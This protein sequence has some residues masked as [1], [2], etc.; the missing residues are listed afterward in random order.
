MKSRSQFIG[1]VLL[2]LLVLIISG[3]SS[4]KSEDGIPGFTLSPPIFE[5]RANPG[6]RL[7]EVVSVYNSGGLPLTLKTSLEN[8]KPLGE[9]GQVQTT[10]ESD[11]LPSLKEWIIPSVDSITIKRGETKNIPF[12][13]N[14][15]VDAEPGGHFA[16][17]LLA[18]TG[19]STSGTGTA[20]VQKIGTLVLLTVSGN[21]R[22]EAK[23][24]EFGPRSEIYWQD[25]KVSFLLRISNSGT[26]HVR[27]RGFLTV[28]NVFGRQ[29]SQVELDGKN[30]LPGATREFPVELTD[31]PWLLGPYTA[32]LSLVYGDQNHNL[33]ASAGFTVLPWRLL[34]TVL[35]LGY[36]L[37]RLRRRLIKAIS[38]LF[39]KK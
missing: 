3:P 26:V 32:T 8:L 14:V 12:R 24:I 7:E 27:P 10:D 23:I 25:D 2:L 1:P 18:T 9:V 22:E 35:L 13:I 20:T 39:G 38:I 15:P 34:L 28:Q 6:D 37:Y 4:V 30:I 31:K 11:S 33:S 36:I 16:T 17:L 29:V 19:A 5:L 21:A